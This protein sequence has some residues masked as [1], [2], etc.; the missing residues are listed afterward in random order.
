MN[1]TTRF[2]P[3]REWHRSGPR[4]IAGV[5]GGLAEQFELPVTLVR[6]GFVLFTIL[7]GLHA[8]GVIAYLVLWFLM[9]EGQGQSSGLDRLVAKVESLTED[10]TATRNRELDEL[11]L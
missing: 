4:K 2:E 5:C 6:A 8:A 1:E 10:R 7:P 3:L 9:P 11:D